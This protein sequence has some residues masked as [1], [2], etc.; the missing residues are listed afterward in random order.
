MKRKYPHPNQKKPVAKGLTFFAIRDGVIVLFVLELLAALGVPL[1]RTLEVAAPALATLVGGAS[2]FFHITAKL[3]DPLY[4]SRRTILHTADR[5]VC[6]VFFVISLFGVFFDPVP[7][8]VLWVNVLILSRW[9]YEVI[10]MYVDDWLA[11]KRVLTDADC[12]DKIERPTD[13]RDS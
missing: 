3:F 12:P 2:V 10:S 13:R 8:F 11:K 5:V 9:L 4:R 6:S 7:Q 1:P